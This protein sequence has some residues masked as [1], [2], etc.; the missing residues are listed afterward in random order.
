MGNFLR[1]R[2]LS[3]IG[4]VLDVDHVAGEADQDQDEGRASCPKGGGRMPGIGIL[5]SSSEPFE[6]LVFQTNVARPSSG[7]TGFDFRW[8]RHLKSLRWTCASEHFS[9]NWRTDGLARQTLPVLAASGSGLRPSRRP[10]RL[11]SRAF[12]Q[13]RF[14]RR[15]ALARTH[16]AFAAVRSAAL[17][18]A[19]RQ[20]HPPPRRRSRVHKTFSRPIPENL[21]EPEH[22]GAEHLKML[23]RTVSRVVAQP[24]TAGNQI[25][26]LVNG[27]A[28]FPAM[29]AAIESAKK[30]VSLSTYIFDNDASGR[31]FVAALARAVKRG[32]A[33]R[34]LD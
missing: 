6:V 22:E 14:P 11:A 33:V 15:H 12:E 26:P 29:L 17:P 31:Q 1:A 2:G 7:Q 19:R 10:A 34:V 3:P 27:D 24:L 28:A 32:V 9:R 5:Q 30:S 25:E 21:G 13:T 8:G 20:P 23:A 18:R 16:L 4:S